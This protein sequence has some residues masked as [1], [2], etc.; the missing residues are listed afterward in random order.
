MLRRI[1]YTALALA[2]AGSAFLN[3]DPRPDINL[4]GV[5]FLFIAFVVWFCW[6]EIIAGYAYH[7][8][9]RLPRGEATGLMLVRFAPM[10]LRELTSRKRRRA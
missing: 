10:Y 7:E 4:F 6:H 2:L 8:E 3:A 5:L 1:F 9:S